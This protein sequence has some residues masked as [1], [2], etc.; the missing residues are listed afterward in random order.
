M[1][2][3]SLLPLSVVQGFPVYD[4][5][6]V[7]H[8][9]PAE[10]RQ[11]AAQIAAALQI[12]GVFNIGERDNLSR[13]L[14]PIW[15]SSG[16]LKTGFALGGIVLFGAFLRVY[17]L[18][19]ESP[20]W[21][22]IVTL[23]A[24]DAPGLSAFLRE[25]RASDPPMTPVYFTVAW[26]WSRLG[27]GSVLWMRLL[28]VA[29]G[30]ACIPVLYQLGRRL[31]GRNAGLLGSL[32]LAGSLVHVYYSQEIRVYALATLLALVSMYCFVRW[33]ERERGAGGWLAAH[34]VFNALLAFT[35][36]FGVLLFAAQGIFLAF[37]I[38]GP[39]VGSSGRAGARPHLARPHLARPHL[40]AWLV[41]HMVILA[42]LVGWL[43]TIDT[44]TIHDAADWMVRPG[45]REVAMVA[46]VFAGGRPS[47]ENPAAH[48]PGGVSLDLVLTGVVC[49]LIAWYVVR[50]LFWRGEPVGGGL[51]RGR[52]G[53]WLLLIWFLVP[54]AGLLVTSYLWRPCFV[55]RYIL[56]SSV[57]LYV[58]LGAALGEARGARPIGLVLACV[59]GFQLL[60]VGSGPFR[61]DWRSVGAY[62]ESRM[63]P[64]DTVVALQSINYSA[65]RYNSSVPESQ[66]RCVDVWSDVRPAVQEAHL[67]GGDAWV[68]VWLWTEPGNI[69]RSLGESG[70]RYSFADFGGWPGLR[71]YRAPKAGPAK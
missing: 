23:E 3:G 20:W 33:L 64:R 47:N 31:V 43:S 54:A 55:Y 13:V 18:G 34:I 53:V 6:L 9:F 29:L 22:E 38:P 66:V 8:S 42:G 28:S 36:L 49:V 37:F 58:L 14:R 12:A 24:L 70:L 10:K 4:V 59:W 65:L 52:A 62:L 44:A 35:H 32:A 60:A 15:G 11:Q 63:G 2:C 56:F 25:E 39:D 48:L 50:R 27:G 45:W 26:C 21:D 51:L 41:A 61:P 68:V 67:E 1:E 46:A 19:A 71:A 40:G 16:A 57:P 7:R 17:G 5:A 30:L 69:E